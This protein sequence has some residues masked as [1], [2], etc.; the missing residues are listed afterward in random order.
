MPW[1]ESAVICVLSCCL[2]VGGPS[3]P[4][5]L[6]MYVAAG[7][8]VSLLL[9]FM[10]VMV[11]DNWKKEGI[12]SASALL[13]TSLVIFPIVSALDALDNVLFKPSITSDEIE[14]KEGLEMDAGDM[15]LFDGLVYHNRQ[16][17][18]N[19]SFTYR[20]RYSLISLDS[21][22]KA[23]QGD[24][25]DADTARQLAGTD[26]EVFLLT[27][28]SAAGYTQNPISVYYCFRASSHHLHKCIAEVTNTPWNERVTFIFDP[29][30]DTVPKSLHVSPLIDMNRCWRLEAS[31]PL[32]ARRGGGRRVLAS[33]MQV[34]V[35][36]LPNT[37]GGGVFTAVLKAGPR[38]VLKGGL[39]GGGGGIR[40][41]FMPQR[42]ALR[43]YW[44]VCKLCLRSLLLVTL[45]VIAYMPPPTPPCCP[46]PRHPSRM[47]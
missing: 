36:V 18:A 7:L 27:T 31:D 43:I 33:Q 17:Q 38:R 1:L 5:A 21:P 30:G 8:L 41:W 14:G 11:Y 13:F 45:C 10:V 15:A 16:E 22:P 24:H 32:E 40:F 25:M 47:V 29:A 34:T 42:V 20:V 2:A 4:L 23:F 12:R 39:G 19:N 6:V 46:L 26:G 37:E 44:Q 9:L 3:G 35:S 28:P